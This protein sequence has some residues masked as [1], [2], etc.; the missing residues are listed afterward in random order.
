MWILPN[1]ENMR[2]T[3]D[4]FNCRSLAVC[5]ADWTKG[6]VPSQTW[7]LGFPSVFLT[8]PSVFAT[9]H[10]A[11]K[12]KEKMLKCLCT[13]SCSKGMLKTTLLSCSSNGLRSVWSR[14]P[15]KDSPGRL[16]PQLRSADFLALTHGL[17]SHISSKLTNCLYFG[18]CQRYLHN[19]TGNQLPKDPTEPPT[20]VWRSTSLVS[21]AW[22]LCSQTL[23]LFLVP[24]FCPFPDSEWFCMGLI[25]LTQNRTEHNTSFHP[26]VKIL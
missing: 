26:P 18:V 1:Q 24:A 10:I 17:G 12:G 25:L 21:L 19:I 15:R 2:N 23:L 8:L 13:H 6:T 22:G 7:Q 9:T 14:A 4:T 5:S 20:V 3:E 16:A 11:I